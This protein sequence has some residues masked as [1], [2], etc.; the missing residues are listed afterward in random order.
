MIGS[1]NLFFSFMLFILAIVGFVL[2]IGFLLAGGY[3]FLIWYRN[4]Q[5]ESEALNS[6]LLQISL[7]RDNDIKIDAAEQMIG[8][9]ASLGKAKKILGITRK[10]APHLSLEIVGLPGDIRF[11]VHVSNKHRDFVEKQINGA[12]P[13]AEIVVVTEGAAKQKEGSVIGGEYNIFSDDGKVA[14]ASLRLKGSHFK[15][16]KPYKEMATDPLSSITSILAK[17]TEGEGAAIQI[18]ISPAEGEWKKLGKQHISHTKKTEANPETAK[19]S[20]DAKE[21]EAIENKVSKPGFNTIVR[22]VVSS[23]T[24]ETAEVHLENIIHAFSQYEGLNSF[25]K[26]KHWMKGSFVTDFIYRYMPIW[27]KTSVMNSEELATIFHFPN[28][29]VTTPGIHWI[30][31]K[32]AP[33]P[34]N[35]PTTGLYLG[36]S[37]Y[38]GLVRPVYIEKDDRRRHMYIIGKTGSGKSEFLK[39]MIMQDIKAG[40]GLAVVDPHGDLIE[41]VLQ[42]IPPNRA[43]DVI[44]FDP[45]DVERPLG[46]NMLYASTEQQK[47]LVVTSVIGLMYKL[48]DPNKTGIIGPR[49]E[50]AVRN[51]MLTCMYEPGATFMEVVRALT[52]QQFVQEILPKVEDPVIRRYWTDQIA[53]TSD[54]HKSEVLDYIV[55]KFGRFVT[56]KMI[57]NII[58]QSNSAF[59]FRDAM[60]NQK[61]LLINLAKGKIGEENSS[62][63][64]LILVPQILVAAMSR[65]DIPMDQRKDF[66]LY[67]DEFQN[68]ATPDFAQILSEARKYRLNLI[69]ANQFVGQMEEEVKNAI[70]GNVGTIAAFRVGVTDANYLQHEFQPTF[71]EA[72]LI[73]IDRF[74]A[75]MRTLVNGEPVLPFSLDTTKD[76]SKEKA[77]MNPRIAELVKE[78]SRLKYGRDVQVIEAEIAQRARL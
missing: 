78:L 13:D 59:S 34:S 36:K 72:D 49:F 14:F 16:I 63:L 39:Q 26:N 43:E 56:N 50:H 38:R 54:F 2:F 74:N 40:E 21:L 3:L 25:T 8:S 29:S 77:L 4:R 45:S 48:F 55:S 10:E 61:I 46:L 9:L 30:S 32:R 53:Q 52:D 58:G 5:R 27:G 33:A 20:G 1:D 73:N 24:H 66:F 15:P 62:F 60:D 44:L 31:S 37:T 42:M 22:I 35:I 68:F 67:V 11:Y 75:Y 17:M 64:G 76:I 28:K 69:V 51:A 18:L 71:N 19:Y 47:H 70:F 57:R 6:V 7:P 41:D 65:Q 23:S 12:Y